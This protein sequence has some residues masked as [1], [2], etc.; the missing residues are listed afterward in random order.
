MAS[1][2]LSSNKS[3]VIDKVLEELAPLNDI[4]A[5]KIAI[6]HDK[7]AKHFQEPRN[8]KHVQDEI[9]Q[10]AE[11]LLTIEEN[12]STINRNLCR[13]DDDKLVVVKGKPRVF[14]VEWR[15]LH[16]VFLYFSCVYCFQLTRFR[17]NIPN[18]FKSLKRQRTKS[19]RK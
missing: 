12:F 8:R 10:L 4:P 2:I 18:S 19:N 16:S 9:C 15:K 1:I 17:R 14:A 6:L 3:L 13:I 5:N 11:T 7:I